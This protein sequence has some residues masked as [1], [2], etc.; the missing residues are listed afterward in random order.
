[1]CPSTTCVTIS[2][3]NVCIRESACWEVLLILCGVRRTSQLPTS[4]L[5]HRAIAKTNQDI[6]SL[7]EAVRVYEYCLVPLAWASV[8]TWRLSNTQLRTLEE[9]S[10]GYWFHR[11]SPNLTWGKEPH[12]WWPASQLPTKRLW[13]IGCVSIPSHGWHQTGSSRMQ[14][15]KMTQSA[16]L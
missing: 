6:T 3:L 13:R 2:S 10:L 8:S 1:M 11:T 16:S 7:L 4:I 15:H 5:K 14:R 9:S 12:F